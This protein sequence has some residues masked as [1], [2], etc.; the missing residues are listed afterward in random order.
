MTLWSSRTLKKVASTV[1]MGYSSVMG[2]SLNSRTGLSSSLQIFETVDLEKEV[3]HKVSTTLDTFLVDTPFTTISIIEEIKAD[4]LLVYSSKIVVSK[5]LFLC[6]G[7]FRTI[8]PIR[9]LRLLSRNPF[10]ESARSSV[11]SY[12]CALSCSADSAFMRLF[13]DS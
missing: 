11:R 8:V 4:S 3:P 1:T 13:N 5:E 12:G 7:T 10:L 9:V 6:L 2:R